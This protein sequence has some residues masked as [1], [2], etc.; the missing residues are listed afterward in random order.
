MMEIRKL[1]Y[2]SDVEKPGFSDLEGLLDLR[3][4]GLEEILFL[5]SVEGEDRVKGAESYGLKSRIIEREI[6]SLSQLWE[7]ARVEEV[8]CR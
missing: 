6:S 3:K 1:L 4:L 7:R 2:A 8:S 5:K